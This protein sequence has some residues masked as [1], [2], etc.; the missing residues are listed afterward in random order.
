[1]GPAWYPIALAVVALPAA[2]LGGWVQQQ[3]GR[4]RAA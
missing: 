4:A 3:R 2:W 1:V